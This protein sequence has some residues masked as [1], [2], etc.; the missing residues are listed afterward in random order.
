MTAHWE[1]LDGN[2]AAARV[3]YALS[4][5][6]SIYPITPASPM[7]EYCD[8]WSAAGQPN[9]WGAVPDVVEM[10]SEAGAAGRA[11][12]RAP[13]GR[14]GDDVHGV[15]GPAAHDPEH[16]Q[17]RRRADAGG[18]PRRGAHA[19]DPRAL[20]LRRPQRR[21]ARPRDRAGR[22]CPPGRSRRRTTSRSSPTRRRSGR[23][24]RSCTS[25]T[26]SARQPRGRQDRRARR[27][28]PARAGPRGRPARLPPPRPHLRRR[29]SCAARRRTPTCSSRRARRATRSTPPCPGI[30]QEVFDEL[31]ARTGR[32]LPPRRVPRRARRRPRRRAHGLRRG[33]RRRDGRRAG[34]RRRAGR[35]A[36]RSACTSPFPADELMAALPPTV[37][38]IAVLDRTK[39]PGAVGEP[40][41]LDVVAAL[42]EAMDAD[43]PPFGRAPRVI[44]GRYGLSSKEFTPAMVKPRLRR[45]ARRPAQAP[46]HRRH[47]RRRDP[48][49]PADRPRRS[50]SPRPAGEVQAL[51]FGLGSD[52]TV[53]ANKASVKIIGEGTDL[54]A[55]GY[56]VY[57]SKKSGSVTVSHLRFGPEP[58]RSTYLV[59]D[60]DFVACH[61]FGLLESDAG[62]RPRQARRDVPAQLP[63]RPR[64]GL[65][66]PP[67]EV[68]QP[69]RRQA[70][71]TS[72]SSTPIAVAAETGMGNRINTVMQPCFFHLVGRAARRRGASPGSRRR[73]RRP[74]RK[75]G[76]RDRPAQ[77]R[78]HR[79]L[80][81]AARTMCRPGRRSTRCRSRRRSSRTDAPDF[82]QRVTA[83]LMAGEGDL[84]PVCAL[85]VDGTF[86]TRHD[87]VREARHRPGDPGLGSRRS[88]STAASAPSSARTRRS[89]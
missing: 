53:G 74:T 44:G 59:D 46:L 56:F 65:G 31:A 6:I 69:A 15:A 27:R 3:A 17:D 49:E 63:V 81:R 36:S 73:S 30:V 10:Q 9:L 5:V 48:P 89:G 47:L 33:R 42:A 67:A 68:Q 75:R 62:A 87:E 80:A 72:G 7:A 50:A 60:A 85:P 55:Q 58:I 22:C 88:A 12:R 18:H 26:G 79:P 14:A 86:P 70:A 32:R 84:L 20:D 2:E 76:E 13:E 54:F 64:R 51:F 1:C 38:S 43:E 78:R 37:R 34:R 35:A 29:R 39:E 52:G 82:V 11:A 77:L 40:L 45:A 25:S 83:R 24:C 41:Y 23:G 57:D 16:V 28:R 21:H 8:D 61:Q 71:S 19:R 66:A 4:E